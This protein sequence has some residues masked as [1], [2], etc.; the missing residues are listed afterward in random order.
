MESYE[1]FC[2]A[3]LAQIQCKVKMEQRSLPASNSTGSLI[4]FHGVAVLSPLLSSKQREEIRELKARS[5]CKASN[6]KLPE[7]RR[8]TSLLNVDGP[9]TKEAC[10]LLHSLLVTDEIGE[11]RST[12]LER[13][14]A[15]A[16]MTSDVF[17]ERSDTSN[18][19][20]GSCLDRLVMNNPRVNSC[21]NNGPKPDDFPKAAVHAHQNVTAPKII[22]ATK[23]KAANS[24][25]T[26]ECDRQVEGDDTAEIMRDNETHGTALDFFRLPTEQ[27]FLRGGLSSQTIAPSLQI[28][29]KKSREYRDRQRQQKVL[30]NLHFKG[31]AE[32]LFDKENNLCARKAGKSTRERRTGFGKAKLPST[33]LNL[34]PALPTVSSL[35]FTYFP[36]Q[37][38]ISVATNV[39]TAK[40]TELLPY[41]SPTLSEEESKKDKIVDADPLCSNSGDQ[42]SQ[43]QEAMNQMYRS[44]NG[45]F[46]IPNLPLSE[47]PVLSRKWTCSAQRLLVNAPVNVGSEVVEQQKDN[48]SDSPTDPP[49]I[50][51][52]Q[53]ESI[54]EL[55]VNLNS[56]KALIT[57]LQT[58]LTSSCSVTTDEQLLNDGAIPPQIVRECLGIKCTWDDNGTADIAVAELL[59][60]KGDGDQSS[61][62]SEESNLQPVSCVPAAFQ[63]DNPQDSVVQEIHSEGMSVQ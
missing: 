4:R 44:Q 54:S 5:S 34:D 57:D 45:G 36:K 15:S 11:T 23:H 28:L 49:K 37:N 22:V 27:T 30:K 38:N 53:R 58:T 24:T 39:S 31:D 16:G 42:V 56:L 63:A 19:H 35:H 52:A 20:N 59:E 17:N 8:S 2:K 29:L 1:E 46:M 14:H 33:L 9:L 26:Q 10:N 48:R 62:S 3:H 43:S 18:H 41:L 60:D 61:P 7:V 40:I 6:E 12:N 51:V 50:N 13:A 25:N 47:S 55:E 32:N 21:T